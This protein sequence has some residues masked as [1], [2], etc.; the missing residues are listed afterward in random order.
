MMIGSWRNCSCC[1]CAGD[2][3]GIGGDKVLMKK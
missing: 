3:G 1:G 2:E